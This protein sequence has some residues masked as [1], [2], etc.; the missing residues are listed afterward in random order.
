MKQQSRLCFMFFLV[1]TDQYISQTNLRRD[2]RQCME[3][4][5]LCRRMWANTN[6]VFCGSF[7]WGFKGIIVLWEVTFFFIVTYYKIER[8]REF[9]RFFFWG[10]GNVVSV[11]VILFHH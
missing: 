10:G 7:H 9:L 5:F 4:S 11:G 3:R 1:E 8:E 6:H 2:Q